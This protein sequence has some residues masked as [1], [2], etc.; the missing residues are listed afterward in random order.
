VRASEHTVATR[1]ELELAGQGFQRI[2]ASPADD[3]AIKSWDS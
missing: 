1:R 3:V 2:D